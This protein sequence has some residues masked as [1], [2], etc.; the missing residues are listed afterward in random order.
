VPRSIRLEVEIPIAK[1]KKYKSIG[2][3]DIPAELIQAIHKLIN[4]IW[5][6]KELPDQWKQEYVL[7]PQLFIF[8]LEYTIR[9]VQEN[10]VGLKLNWT[11]QL[12][13]YGNDTNLLRDN[14]DNIDKNK[15]A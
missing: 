15:D 7:K 1:L 11:H 2:N 6:K 13:A 8:T 9:K 14:I 12:L 5:N 3:D 10:Q 4:F